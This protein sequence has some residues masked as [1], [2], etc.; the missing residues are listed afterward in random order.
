MAAIAAGKEQP[1]PGNANVWVDSDGGSCLRTAKPRSYVSA[2]AC[3]DLPAALD[4]AAQGDLVLVRDGTYGGAILSARKRVTVQGT[5][6]GRPSFGQLVVSGSNLTLRHLLV[7]NRDDQPAR[8][9]NFAFLD[10][11][12][13]VCGQDNRFDD[14][15]VDGLRHPAGDPALKGGLH[16]VDTAVGT[17]FRNGEIRGVWDSK[18]FQGGADNMLIEN[19][20]FRDIRLT[21]QGGAVDIHNECA[22]VNGG[23]NQRWIGNRFVLCPGMALFFTNYNGGP[24]YTGVLVERNVFTHTLNDAGL[25]HGGAAFVIGDGANG[26]NQVNGWTVRYN[27]FEVPPVIES[28]PSI[29]DDN[30]SA[31]FYGNVGADGACGIPEWTYSYNVG[32]T[33]GGKGEIRIRPGI[34]TQSRPNQ[35]PFY[36]DATKLDFRLRPGSAAIDRGDST[37]FPPVDADG[38]NRPLG[39][40]PDAG[41]YEFGTGVVIAGGLGASAGARRA[42]SATIR[43]LQQSAASNLL[44]SLG[45]NDSTR[46]RGFAAAWR[47]SFGWLPAA[48][49]DVA[50]ALAAGDRSTRS[51]G[52]QFA[53]LGMPGPYYVRR[54]RDVEVIVL[55]STRVSA[56][57]TAW[58][59]RTLATPATRFRMVVLGD[60]PFSCASEL[61]DAAIADDWIPLLER[62]GVRLVVS[63]S[64]PGYQRFRKGRITY[65][66]GTVVPLQAKR[67][68]PCPK[69]YP[70]RLAAKLGPALVHVAAGGGR[71]QVRAVGLDGKTIDRFRVG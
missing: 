43:R 42:A 18:G 9:C 5:G 24:P 17:V 40:A 25:W 33:C 30:S 56:A 7:E 35:A 50:G 20:T 59:Q 23:N 36:V 29:A 44:V 62:S 66:A 55:D 69:G 67:F 4:T 41:A 16:V 10:F 38:V 52:Y 54:L 39:A 49:I 6:P 21:P 26:Q 1:A 47:S 3:A 32:E 60:S 53:T 37:A 71:A 51:G 15:I 48:R 61:A 14:V 19:T 45:N 58:L 63:G 28:T 31:R 46:G 70:R 2:Q 22:Y 64:A 8:D 65:V 12:L 34:N 11:T 13:F 57:Q 27:T 68:P